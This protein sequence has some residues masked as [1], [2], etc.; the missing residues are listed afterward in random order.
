MSIDVH[1]DVLK[2]YFDTLQ[3][4]DSELQGRNALLRV[5]FIVLGA[6]SSWLVKR[7]SLSLSMM[8]TN[9]RCLGG[10]LHRTHTINSLSHCCSFV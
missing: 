4:E 9:G 6:S 8:M 3:G 7:L 10:P 5:E 1:R 2:R